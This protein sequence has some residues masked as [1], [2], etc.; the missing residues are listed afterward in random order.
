MTIHES[1]LSACVVIDADTRDELP[2]APDW[3]LYAATRGEE[4]DA[5]PTTAL[6]RRVGDTWH[7]V[8]AHQADLHPDAIE[9]CV[10]SAADRRE[11]AERD[12]EERGIREREE[13]REDAYWR[14]VDRRIDAAREDAECDRRGLDHG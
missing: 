14:E 2:G 10:L 11:A 8:P 1:I 12:A 7:H 13:A 3:V 6:A 9:V 5:E 4:G